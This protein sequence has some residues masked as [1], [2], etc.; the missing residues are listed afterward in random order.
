MSIRELPLDIEEIFDRLNQLSVLFTYVQNR[1][2]ILNAE[3]VNLNV[4]FN[5]LEYR[6]DAIDNSITNINNNNNNNIVTLQ[7]KIEM[8]VC[9]IRLM[10]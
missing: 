9:K 6:L 7:N 1:L 3:L 4:R 8:M 10:V 2:D 5:N